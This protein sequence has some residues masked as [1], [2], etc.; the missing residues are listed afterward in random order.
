MVSI[1][2][3]MCKNL[4]NDKKQPCARGVGFFFLKI[5]QKIARVLTESPTPPGL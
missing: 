2:V 5:G 4:K 3:F 1:K